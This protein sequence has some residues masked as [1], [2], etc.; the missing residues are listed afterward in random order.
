MPAPGI[1]AIP[2]PSGTGTSH[3]RATPFCCRAAPDGAD[4]S[5]RGGNMMVALYRAAVAGA[6]LTAVLA[7]ASGA[8][9]QTANKTAA[10]LENRTKGSAGA[11]VTVYEMSDFQC[12][13]CRQ[14]ALETFPQID[15]EYIA[16]GKVR[17]V[18]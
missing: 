7:F 4:P 9:A 16:T 11:P 14:F 1:P 13:Y 17:W 18:F 10:T 6:G 5:I 3:W 15:R 2:T 8:E 12:P